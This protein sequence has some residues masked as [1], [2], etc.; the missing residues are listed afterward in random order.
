MTTTAQT[1][2]VFDAAPARR[3]PLGAA[4]RWWW[5]ARRGAIAKRTLDVVGASVGLIAAAPVWGAAA[6][7]IKLSDGGP[8][9]FR[10]KRVGQDGAPFECLKFRTMRVGADAQHAALAARG[11]EHGAS[12]VTFKMANDPRITAVGR[13]LRKASLDELPQ[14]WCV[15]RGEMSLVGPRPALPSEVAR[16][17]VGERRRLRAKP[18]LTCIWQVSGRSQIPFPEQVEM[19]VDYIR[20]QSLGLDLA[21]IL[22]TVP[23]V[24]FA[25]GAC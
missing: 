13:W 7:A 12:G 24:L 2:S 11:N 16:Y 19:D 15:L 8:V 21:L 17:G 3:A 4:L 22:K 25:R 14:L 5:H 6:L 20:R 23:A 18:G 10:Q 1:Y 9:F